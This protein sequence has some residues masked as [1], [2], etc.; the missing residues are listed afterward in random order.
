MAAR[1]FFNMIEMLTK[2]FMFMYSTRHLLCSKTP[3]KHM[4][5]WCTINDVYCIINHHTYEGV[6]IVQSCTRSNSSVH[7]GTLCWSC[8]ASS[9]TA[10]GTQ[11]TNVRA[12][13]AVVS[14]YRPVPQNVPSAASHS[15]SSFVAPPRLLLVCVYAIMPPIILAHAHVCISAYL[16][17]NLVFGTLLSWKLFWPV[18][19]TF[20]F[21][22]RTWN[23]YAW[24]VSWCWL[25]N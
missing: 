3:L 5:F 2:F 18:Y 21:P 15:K 23:E 19:T 4:G 22:N 25:Y 20:N 8:L 11:M 1:S 9:Q 6:F 12:E 14:G 13:P 16:W 10:N 17:A 7:Y 24:A